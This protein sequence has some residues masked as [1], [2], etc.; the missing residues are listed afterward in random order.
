MIKKIDNKAFTLIEVLVVVAIIG[1][2]TLLAVPRF[3]GHTQKAEL[4]R[5]QHDIKAMEREIG[6]ELINKD[7]E[8]DSWEDNNKDL[9]QLVQNKKLFDNKG[10]AK[11]V[12]STD[13]T[14]KVIPKEYKD[15]INT[16]LKGIFYINSGGKVY[17]EHGKMPGYSDEEIEDKIK[18]GFIPIATAEELNNV[19][20]ATLETYGKGTEWE[21]KY[22]GG[23]DKKYVQVKNINLSIYSEEGWAPIATGSANF[24]GTYDG[25]NYVITGLEVKGDSKDSQGLFGRTKGATILNVGLID[26]KVT[27][28]FSVGGLVGYAYESTIENSYATGQVTSQ[29]FVGGLVGRAGASIKI[30]NSYAT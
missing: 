3:I 23:L 6:A 12:E 8:F 24:T 26:N 27:G 21:G 22:T 14:Y 29:Y 13:G 18:Q 19:R 9:N 30:S 17:Y 20:R 7:D 10:V 16:K 15:K 2:L 28:R 5:I 11:E 25:G 4:V 1:I